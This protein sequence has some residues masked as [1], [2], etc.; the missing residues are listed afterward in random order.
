M[1][2]TELEEKEILLA[3]GNSE[4]RLAPAQQSADQG[5]VVSLVGTTAAEDSP[6]KRL[7]P[8]A[9]PANARPGRNWPW[10]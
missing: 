10:F 2:I 9:D 3:G 8:P 1:E 7:G 6:A 5:A 4:M